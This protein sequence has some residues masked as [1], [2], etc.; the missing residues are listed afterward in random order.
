MM[1]GSAFAG[2]D[3]GSNLNHRGLVPEQAGISPSIVRWQGV[4]MDMELKRD[5]KSVIDRIVHLRD[6]L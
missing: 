1:E 4:P 5:A 3:F 6:S 2:L